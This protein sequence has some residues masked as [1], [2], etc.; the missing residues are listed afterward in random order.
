MQ[1]NPC[2]GTSREAV[3]PDSD[4]YKRRDEGYM[5]SLADVSQKAGEVNLLLLGDLDRCAQTDWQQWRTENPKI[6]AALSSW[7]AKDAT[8][9]MEQLK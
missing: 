6:V 7:E 3:L 5:R 9:A 2:D 8:E 4:A 1:L